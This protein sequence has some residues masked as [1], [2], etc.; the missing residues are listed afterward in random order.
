MDDIVKC[1]RKFDEKE[2]ID[3]DLFIKIMFKLKLTRKMIR[4]LDEEFDR[5][6]NEKSKK[7]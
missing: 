7:K 2:F 5:I 3:D 1:L 4:N 6:Q